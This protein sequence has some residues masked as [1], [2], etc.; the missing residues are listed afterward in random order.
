[1]RYADLSAL[2]IVRNLVRKSVIP[3]AGVEGS[4]TEVIK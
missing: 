3:H 2:L 1:M 4:I